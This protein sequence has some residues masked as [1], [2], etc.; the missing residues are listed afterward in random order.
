ML[1]R[2]FNRLADTNEMMFGK[3]RVDYQKLSKINTRVKTP[4]TTYIPSHETTNQVR[5]PIIEA[6]KAADTI[7]TPK[8]D[9]CFLGEPTI[10]C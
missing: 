4:K 7:H 3:G 10:Q 9:I 5:N 8:C 6:M 2:F 1:K